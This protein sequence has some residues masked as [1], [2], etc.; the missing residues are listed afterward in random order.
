VGLLSVRLLGPVE[1]DVRGR[2]VALSRMLERALVA[3]LALD[4]GQP[5]SAQRLIDDLWGD[6]LPNNAPASLQTLVYRLRRSLGV[7][8]GVAVTRVG[9]ATP[10]RSTPPRSTPAASVIW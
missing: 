3:R 10:S 7:E 5:L 8:G 1:V 2:G 9:V 6:D 4:P